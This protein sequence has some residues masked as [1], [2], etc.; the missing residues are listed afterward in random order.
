MHEEA[1]TIA[2][3]SKHAPFL[4]TGKNG[5]QCCSMHSLS[6]VDGAVT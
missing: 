5:K 4:R 6:A 3:I 2:G 1:T